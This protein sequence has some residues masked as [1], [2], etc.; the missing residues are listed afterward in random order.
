M[1]SSL[2]AY[3]RGR[4]VGAYVPGAQVTKS[5]PSQGHAFNAFNVPRR[6]LE[7]NFTHTKTQDGEEVCSLCS[8]CLHVKAQEARYEFVNPIIAS[9]LG[10]FFVASIL[11]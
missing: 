7:A 8:A 5:L 11:S 9:S 2:T 10:Q 6:M 3:V 1:G 4:H